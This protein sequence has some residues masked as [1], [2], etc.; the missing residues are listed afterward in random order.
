MIKTFCDRC[1]VET[2]N[3]QYGVSY[4]LAAAFR[5]HY[6]VCKDCQQIVVDQFR[7]LMGLEPVPYAI[8]EK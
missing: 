8:V 6:D 5:N 3:K 7:T 1:N 4:P 2:T